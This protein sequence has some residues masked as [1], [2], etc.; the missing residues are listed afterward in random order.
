MKLRS[1]VT[2]FHVVQHASFVSVHFADGLQCR[3]KVKASLFFRLC[4]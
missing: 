3:A 2:N 4:Y 1:Q